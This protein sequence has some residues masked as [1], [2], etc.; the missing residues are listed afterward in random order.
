MRTVGVALLQYAS[1]NQ[2]ALPPAL[3]ALPMPHTGPDLTRCPV[4][5]PHDPDGEYIYVTGFKKITDI[6]DP[7]RTILVYESPTNHRKVI[8]VLYADGAV[9]PMTMEEARQAGLVVPKNP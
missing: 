9:R 4:A 6:H 2:D 7:S 5:D 3:T 8:N 1:T